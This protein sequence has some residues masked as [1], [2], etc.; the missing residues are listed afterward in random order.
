MTPTYLNKINPVTISQEC[1][2]V[3]ISNVIQNHVDL[4]RI[5]KEL[6]EQVSSLNENADSL[7]EGKCLTMKS[8][9][10]TLLENLK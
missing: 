4:L 5:A 2:P 1:S 3:H 10:D 7:G 9:A 6:A 8:L